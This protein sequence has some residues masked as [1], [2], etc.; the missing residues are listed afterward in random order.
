MNGGV[1]PTGGVV[2]AALPWAAWSSLNRQRCVIQ[3]L[4]AD[5]PSGPVLPAPDGGSGY[6]DYETCVLKSITT[7]SVFTKATE[8]LE[9]VKTADLARPEIYSISPRFSPCL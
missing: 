4:H 7:I 6:P 3:T 5:R 8:K 2:R 9:A 1:L